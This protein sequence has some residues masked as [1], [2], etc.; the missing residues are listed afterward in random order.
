[1]LKTP[2]H[3]FQAA[4]AISSQGTLTAVALA[5]SLL[6]SRYCLAGSTCL[7]SSG[8]TLRWL[9]LAV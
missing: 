4:A 3:N 1:M 9:A 2:L 5:A 8:M 6:S 7:A